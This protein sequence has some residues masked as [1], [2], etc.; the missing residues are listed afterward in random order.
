MDKQKEI[1]SYINQVKVLY[2][3]EPILEYLLEYINYLYG[4]K[5]P[6]FFNRKHIA[7]KLIMD[8]DGMLKMVYSPESFYYEFSIPKRKGGERVISTP[9][10]SLKYIQKW[11]L[12]NILEKVKVTESSYA[13]VKGK[14]IID[15]ANQ[16]LENKCLLKMDLKDFF[17]SIKINRVI[18]LFQYLG[19]PYHI[20]YSLAALCCKDDSLP[21]GA[22]T[23][24][25]LS[26]LIAYKLDKRISAFAKLNRL[27]YTRYAD[28]IALSGDN[29]TSYTTSY[30]GWIITNEGFVVNKKKTQLIDGFDKQKIITGISISGKK[31]SLPKRT[32]RQLKQEA[33]YIDKFGMKNHLEKLNI[34][35]PIYKERFIGKLNFWLLIEPNNILVKRVLKKLKH[36]D[37][38]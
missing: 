13:F 27:T 17:P 21:Q 11:I 3:D 1:Q 20:A 29:I 32:K 2:K 35:D 26:N 24:P 14:T 16:H 6:V 18:A 22:S 4:K 33:F 19:Y 7:S 31:L 28:D 38:R 15:N 25:Y 8:Y 12:K 9:Y 23:S 5:L 37:I 30:I 36:K 10:P 34:F